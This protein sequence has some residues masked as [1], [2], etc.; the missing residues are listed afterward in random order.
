MKL[1]IFG[2]R[3]IEEFHEVEQAVEASGICES[4]KALGLGQAP[5]RF[6]FL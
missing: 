6:L 5:C 4:G 1:V 3:S 2:S